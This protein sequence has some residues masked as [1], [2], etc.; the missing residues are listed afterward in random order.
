MAWK[1]CSL[2]GERRRF[3][4]AAL[5]GEHAVAWMC[6]LYGISRKTGF[7]W[8]AR[9]HPLGR[10][11]LQNRSR[12]P[13]R[14]P[15]R[16]PPR[17][18]AA[19]RYW[20]RKRPRWGAKKIHARLRGQRPRQGRPSVRTINHWLRRWGLTRPRL[21]RSRRGPAQT[22]RALTRARRPNEV[23]TVDFKGRFHTGDGTRVDPL[24]VRDLFSR[25]VLLAH[26]LSRPRHD[27]VQAVMARLFARRG[28]P[29]VIRVDQGVPFAGVGAL[30]LSRRS[31]WWLRLGIRV[32]FTRKGCPQDNGAHQQ[33]PRVL[34]AE[35]ATPPAAT[36]RGQQQRTARWVTRYNEERPHEALGQRTPAEFYRPSPRRYRGRLPAPSYPQGWVTRQ[37]NSRGW[38]SWGGRMRLIGRAFTGLRVGFKPLRSGVRAV[39]LERHLIGHVH[40]T[41]PGGLR[42]AQ[43][44][45]RRPKS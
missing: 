26:L 14:S 32:E 6:R 5:R 8:L 40:D 23:W 13:A 45:K 2:I 10:A 30:D 33:M 36:F 27:T 19:V 29:Q 22:R 15:Q 31:V 18:Q 41:D 42:P 12:R 38:I 17:W 7:K 34:K 37:V 21:Q 24:T 43:G 16:L 11:G 3:V 4:L 1:D 39:Y 35:T 28:C 20:R 44:R 25:F 9:Y